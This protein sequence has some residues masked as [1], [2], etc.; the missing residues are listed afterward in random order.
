MIEDFA[1]KE[2]ERIWLGQHSRKF[3]AELQKI[4]KRKLR[5]LN[6][7]EQVEWLGLV[8][9]NQLEKLKGDRKGC[10][11]IRINQQWRLCFEWRNGDAY[12]V[13]IVDYH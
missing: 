5:I 10:Y 4:A 13:E 6:N 2:T 11:N 1:C 3:S 8:P 9:G 12:A 7:V